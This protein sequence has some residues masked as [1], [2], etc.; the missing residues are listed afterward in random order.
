MIDL[1]RAQ[2]LD[3]AIGRIL[4]YLVV[5][6]GCVILIEIALLQ[7]FYGL[8]DDAKNLR[9]L[10]PGMAEE[11]I[12]S[13]SIQWVREDLSRFGFF[14]PLYPPMVLLLYKVAELFG[15]T[16]FF[17]NNALLVFLIV[18]FSATVFESVANVGRWYVL[19][20]SLAFPYTYDLLQHPSLQQKLVM[21]SGALLLWS[22]SMDE[23]SKRKDISLALALVLGVSTKTQFLIFLPPAAL[24]LYQNAVT[25][26]S[27][28]SRYRFV[29]FVI[30]SVVAAG[31]LAYVGL[32]G[33]YS[34]SGYSIEHAWS[35]L[36]G[37]HGVFYAGLIL[38]GGRLLLGK[39]TLRERPGDLVPL[40]AVISFTML[41]L[42]WRFFG[43]YLLSTVS[44]AT[45]ALVAQIAHKLVGNRKYW[46]APLALLSVTVAIYRPVSMFGRLQDLGNIVER[47]RNFEQLGVERIAMPCPEGAQS[48]QF[49]LEAY[50][51][52]SIGTEF[53]RKLDVEPS[54][55]KGLAILTDAKMC[56]RMELA[57]ELVTGCTLTPLYSSVI[58]GGYR[59]E[60]VH[61]Q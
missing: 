49:Y 59:L 8:M 48:M 13:F 27:I 21:A 39:H 24:L 2:N 10:M 31:F 1:P 18:Y 30:L 40:A 6:L 60:Q 53:I 54:R 29:A 35:N 55:T 20:F 44:I 26:G 58:H 46:I 42:P 3:S 16:A 15:P 19:V 37:P 4:P 56:G 11:G 51:A 36:L 50:G 23:D 14:R 28:W 5:G 17:I 45:G 47:A 61:C 22:A 25:K 12:S 57:E 52:T 33:E 41:M 34:S 7:P 38:V 43:G 9:V 32:Q